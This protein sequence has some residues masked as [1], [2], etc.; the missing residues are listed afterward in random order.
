[1]ALIF[2]VHA[3]VNSVLDTRM[4]KY[5]NVS[6]RD[7]EEALCINKIE[8]YRNLADLFDLY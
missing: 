7:N 2:S 8:F 4:I 5:T 1:M 6:K 3:A